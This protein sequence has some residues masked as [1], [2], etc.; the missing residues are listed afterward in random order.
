MKKVAIILSGCGYLDGAEIHESVITMLSVERAGARYQCFAPNIEQAHVINH[1]SGEVAENE[2]R[3]VL[4]ESAR[5]ARGDI[6]DISELN[7]EDFDALILPGGFGVAK[8][9]CD[10]AFKGT[11]CTIEPSILAACK[12]FAAANKAAGYLCIA[13]AMLPHIYGQGVI[14]TIGKDPGTAEAY[15]TLGGVHQDCEVD[16]IIVDSD[17]K[18][19]TS[20]AYMLA[21]TIS[22]AA[23]GIEKLVKKV[24]ELA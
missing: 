4:V 18:L 24:V 23:S 19:V 12:A 14:G 16:D 6:Y 1:L 7:A 8:N 17:K 11:D 15:S 2:R 13:P 21:H 22:E 10:F 3:N 20:P 9:L 5:I